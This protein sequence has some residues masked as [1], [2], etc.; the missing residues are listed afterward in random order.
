MRATSTLALTLCILSLLLSACNGNTKAPANKQTY[1][2][3]IVGVE[4]LD[5]LDPA[6]AHDPNSINA[7]QMIYTGL[8]GLNDSLQV[9]PQIAASWQ[10]DAKG[11]TWTFHL[12]PHLK[13]P[14]NTNLTS[15][16]VAYSID[17]ALQPSTKS[18][19]APIYLSLIKDSDQLLAGKITTLIGD[20]IL[21]PNPQT[22]VIITKQKAAY[23]LSILTSTCTYVVEKSLITKYGNQ[24]TDHLAEGGGAG[25]FKVS[26]Y[27]HRSN[28]TFVPNT[29]YYNAPPQLKNVTF[30]FYHTAEAAYQD[31]LQKKLDV[32][33]VP[34]TDLNQAKKKPEFH[35]VKQLW[36]N[37]YVM[38]YLAKPFDNIHIRQAFALAIN[39]AAI[40][41]NVWHDTLTPTN[42]IVP[43]GMIGYNPDLKG[44]D[45]T[46]SL[47]GNAKR[48]Q[49]LLQQGLKE[50]GWTSVYDMPA[51]TLNYA[52]NTA[53]FDQEVSA[54]VQQWQKVLGITVSAIP[55]NGSSLLDDVTNATNNSQGIQMWGL[56]WVGEYPDPQDWLSLQFGNGTPDN[57]MNYGQNTTQDAAQQQFTQQKLQVADAT[58][59]DTHQSARTQ[60]YQ[61]AEQQIVDDVAWVPMEQMNSLFLRSTNIVGFI[62]NAQGTVPPD[63][64]AS[65]YRAQSA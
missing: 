50:E 6:L 10:V 8:V 45:G 4:D 26:H 59:G 28:I 41:K 51:I 7:I 5:T 64:W 25:P 46:Q 62:D 39:K 43:E 56:A 20:S 40:A 33:Q 13:F 16:D 38:N 24:F 35:Q 31:Y 61:Q 15:T 19:V 42:H 22:V 34:F 30:T 21:T 12:R 23:F 55:E 63:D 2:V 53:N 52:S 11:T 3:P 54:L 29:H 18:T 47:T 36:T 57:N 44:P 60:T 49:Q 1:S 14:D 17:R 27:V 9:S 37:Y 48:A 32:V 58:L 65:I